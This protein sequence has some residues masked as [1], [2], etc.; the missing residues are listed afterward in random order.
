M[1]PNEFRSAFITWVESIKNLVKNEVVA[2]DGKTLRGSQNKK[3]GKS[4]IHMVSAWASEMN[5]VLGQVKTEEKS[6]EITA[7][8][9]LL[10]LLDI[11]GCIVTI[12]AM[13]CQ[14]KIAAKIIEK[15]ADYA[16][17][18]KKNQVT[19]HDDVSTHAYVFRYFTEIYHLYL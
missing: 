11:S 13:G 2:F 12:D 3:N 8:P 5:M 19:L 1:D 18:L 16:L 9:Q 14:K 4:A 7:I 17:A 15:N 6:N 10:D